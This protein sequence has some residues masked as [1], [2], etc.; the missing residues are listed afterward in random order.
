MNEG[1]RL[2][3]FLAIYSEFLPNTANLYCCTKF[4]LACCRSRDVLQLNQIHLSIIH[5]Q[6]VGKHEDLAQPC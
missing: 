2:M 6:P 4:T 3:N 5:T 1:N